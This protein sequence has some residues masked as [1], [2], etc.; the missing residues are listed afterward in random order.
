MAR[1]SWQVILISLVAIGMTLAVK[2]TDLPANLVGNLIVGAVLLCS[3]AFSIV[4]LRAASDD[5]DNASRLRSNSLIGLVGVA[6]LLS[7]VIANNL[8]VFRQE[9]QI[10]AI[11]ATPVAT[12]AAGAAEVPTAAPKAEVRAESEAAPTPAPITPEEART[13]ARSYI[14][15]VKRGEFDEAYRY[16]PPDVQRR[17]TS[18]EHE[19]HWVAAAG[20]MREDLEVDPAEATQTAGTSSLKFRVQIPEKDPQVLLVMGSAGKLSAAPVQLVK[21]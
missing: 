21:P 19:A 11:P 18:R 6:V 16:L 3:I 2:R 17:V 8:G 1:A 15:L 4:G 7:L 14:A 13:I 10:A 12:A 5:E 9:T 20:E